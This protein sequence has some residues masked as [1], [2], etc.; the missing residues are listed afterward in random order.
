[1]V[2]IKV[3]KHES[4]NWYRT[5]EEYYIKDFNKY[6]NLGVQ[7]HVTDLNTPDVIQHGHYEIIGE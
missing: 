4:W 7:V 5:D 6:G 1:M 3:T 2:K